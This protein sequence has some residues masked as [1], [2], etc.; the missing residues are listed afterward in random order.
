[1]IDFYFWTTPNGYKVMLFLEETD[2][3][4]NIIPV[5]IGTGDQFKPEFLKISPNNKI[6]AIV[7]HN[8]NNTDV[9]ISIFESGAILH[10]LAEKTGQ[11]LPND[12]A[13][14]TEVMQWLFWQMAGLGPMLGQNFH[15]SS[16][17][18]VKIP[19]AIDRFN[20][21]TERLY[22]VLDNCLK[23]REFIA[24]NYSIAD[25]ASYPWIMRYEQE[26]DYLADFPHVDR[27][28]KTISERPAIQRAYK[29]GSA[30]NTAPTIT[31]LSKKILF[32]QNADSATAA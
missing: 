3:E 30:I 1:M 4:F 28:F 25:M 23:D 11:F 20:K 18:S 32:D 15:F 6:P 14:R 19:Y 16:Y 13:K 21:E 24:G 12:V 7:D 8:Q 29:R 22:A 5:N 2:L 31:E 17:A 10:Y 27:W 26:R 9:P